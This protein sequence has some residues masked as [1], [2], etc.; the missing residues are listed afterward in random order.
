MNSL[1]IVVF[2]GWLIAGSFVLS[3][4]NISKFLYAICWITLMVNLLV[5]L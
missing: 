4:P 5:K 3:L 1:N 2:V